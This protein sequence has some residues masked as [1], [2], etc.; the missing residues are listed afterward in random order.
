MSRTYKRNQV[1]SWKLLKLRKENKSNRKLKH[2]REVV[3]EK[4]EN[5]NDA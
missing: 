3:I 5:E 1:E 4:V 2:K